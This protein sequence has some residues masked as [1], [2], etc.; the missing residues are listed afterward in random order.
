MRTP[1]EIRQLAGWL[2]AAGLASLEL[3][4]PRGSLRLLRDGMPAAGAVRAEVTGPGGH[5]GPAA[6]AAAAGEAGA[7]VRAASVGV[8]LDRHPLRREAIAPAGARVR[9]GEAIALLQVGQWLTAVTASRDGVLARWLV[10]PGT[11]VG[12]GTPL[13]ELSDERRH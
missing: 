13:A 2:S 10:E 6:Q 11:T 9:A 12:F 7:V 5:A 4:G 3:H 8:L 1:D